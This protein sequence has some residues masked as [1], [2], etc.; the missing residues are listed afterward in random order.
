MDGFNYYQRA[1]LLALNAK[2]GHMYEGTVPRQVKDQRRATN[3]VARASRR[4][5]RRG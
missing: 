1:I 4:N 3:K 2:K 5:N